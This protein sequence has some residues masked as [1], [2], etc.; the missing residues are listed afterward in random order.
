MI[1]NRIVGIQTPYFQLRLNCSIPAVFHLLFPAACVS[2]LWTICV[3]SWCSPGHDSLNHFCKDVLLIISPPTGPWTVDRVLEFEESILCTCLL[4]HHPASLSQLRY[5]VE[6]IVCVS[7]LCFFCFWVG[8]V[9]FELS[10][11]YFLWFCLSSMCLPSV[12]LS[13]PIVPTCSPSPVPCC[14]SPS[15]KL[16]SS[17]CFSLE[18]NLWDLWA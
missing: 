1:I 15:Y 14:L 6:W 10:E 12:L 9:L 2:M 11:R 18:S 5:L 7:V 3:S 16:R 17:F 4:I 13:F 8:F